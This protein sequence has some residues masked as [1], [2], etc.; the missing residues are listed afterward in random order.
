M[1]GHFSTG[2]SPQW[3]VVPMEEEVSF[4]QNSIII[5]ISTLLLSQGQA[6]EAWEPSTK[7]IL[8]VTSR[9]FAQKWLICELVCRC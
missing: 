6:A 2:Q 9:R 7:V 3:A 4:D 1:E 5:L 8:L